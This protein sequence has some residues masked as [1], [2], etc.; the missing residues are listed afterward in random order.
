MVY[1]TGITKVMGQEENLTGVEAVDLSSGEKREIAAD[2]LII[3][4]GRFPRLVFVPV[5]NG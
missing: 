5:K 2:T 3:G 1:N 4:A